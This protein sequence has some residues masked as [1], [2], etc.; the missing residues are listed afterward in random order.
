MENVKEYKTSDIL[1][2]EDIRP[3][4]IRIRILDTLCSGANH[5]SIDEIYKQLIDEIPT[6]SKTTIYN[7]INLFMEKNLVKK[8]DF[9]DAEM[10]YEYKRNNHGHFFCEKCNQIYDI[11]IDLSADIPKS[12]TGFEIKH[13]DLIYKGVCK[14]CL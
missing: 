4:Y 9:G 13:Q 3:S 11:Q 14:D 6:L 2:S 7:N 5:L 8:L 10:R 12:L 1:L